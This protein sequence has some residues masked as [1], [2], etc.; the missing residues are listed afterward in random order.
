MP[1]PAWVCPFPVRRSIGPV[2]CLCRAD[3]RYPQYPYAE[4]VNHLFRDDMTE[5]SGFFQVF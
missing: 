1:L 2:I 4:Y 3:F 5:D